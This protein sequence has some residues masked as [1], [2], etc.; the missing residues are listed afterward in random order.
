MEIKYALPGFEPYFQNFKMSGLLFL[1]GL[2]FCTFL[3]IWYFMEKKKA[4]MEQEKDILRMSISRA[5][6]TEFNKAILQLKQ[7]VEKLEAQQKFLIRMTMALSQKVHSE[8]IHKK[9]VS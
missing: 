9:R 6:G 8:T 7:S 1:T 3:L 4:L 2:F 5:Q